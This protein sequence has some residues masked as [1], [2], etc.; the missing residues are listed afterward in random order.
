MD[1]DDN[2]MLWLTQNSLT[3]GKKVEKSNEDIPNFSLLLESAKKL[4]DLLQNKQSYFDQHVFNIGTETQFSQ[5]NDNILLSTVEI[6]EGR[7]GFKLPENS[8][9]THFC[10]KNYFQAYVLAAMSHAFYSIFFTFQTC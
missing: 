6:A 8:M 4:V 2:E 9:E 5:S 7:E 1:S 10:R 3:R